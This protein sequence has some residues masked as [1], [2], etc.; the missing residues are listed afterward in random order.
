MFMLFLRNLDKDRFGEMLVEYRKSFANKDNKY[1]QTVS[2]MMDVM[3][4]QPEKQKKNK[5]I[6]DKEK[7]KINPK[8]KSET[9]A[10]YEQ[11]RKPD[12]AKRLEMLLLWQRKLRAYKLS[13][14]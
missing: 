13:G 5:P 2:D 7:D 1:P 6:R 9:V 12:E 11:G 4:Q 3:R 14:Q 8:A 10:S